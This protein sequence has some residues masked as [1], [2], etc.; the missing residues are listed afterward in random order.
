MSALR[1]SLP[2]GTAL[3]REGDLPTTFRDRVLSEAKPI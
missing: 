3:F 2:A 1:L